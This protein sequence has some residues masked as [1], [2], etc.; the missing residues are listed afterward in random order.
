MNNGIKIKANC[1]RNTNRHKNKNLTTS[2][3]SE[4]VVWKDTNWRKIELRLNI[5]QT[6]IYVAKQDNNIIKVRKLQKLILRNL[7]YVKLFS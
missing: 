3:S 5:V 1:G 7:Q 6:K 4:S 2:K